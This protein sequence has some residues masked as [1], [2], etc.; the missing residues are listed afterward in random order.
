M[1]RNNQNVQFQYLYHCCFWLFSDHIT[2]PK[3]TKAIIITE[4]PQGQGVKRHLSFSQISLQFTTGKIG[5]SAQ[6]GLKL[7][8]QSLIF[9]FLPLQALLYIN[10]FH[11]TMCS[12]RII[13]R[14]LLQWQECPTKFNVTQWILSSFSTPTH[15]QTLPLPW[16]HAARLTTKPQWQACASLHFLAS[17]QQEHNTN[18]FISLMSPDCLGGRTPL[19]N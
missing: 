15:Y 17:K 1:S 9:F 2:L 12:S 5:F 4:T 6:E 14:S 19:P 16:P 11:E 7:V 3:R 13:Q 10:L 8:Y 18:Q